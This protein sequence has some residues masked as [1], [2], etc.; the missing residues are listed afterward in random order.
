[1]LRGRGLG[2]GLALGLALGGCAPTIP[3]PPPGT[4]AALH[5]PVVAGAWSPA[6]DRVALHALLGEAFADDALTEAYVAHRQARERMARSGVRLTIGAVEHAPLE[7]L[8][9]GTARARWTVAGE[10]VHAGH[11]HDRRHR[12]EARVA[13]RETDV[14][15]RIVGLWPGR[16]EAAPAGVGGGTTGGGPGD[17]DLL[18]LMEGADG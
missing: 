13:L 17:Q 3:R 8:P 11:R 4:F 1:M 14:G 18:Q 10:V 6:L 12:F 5:A 16:V 7:P 9:D 15:W 2:R